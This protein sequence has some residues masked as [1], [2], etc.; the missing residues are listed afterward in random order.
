MS[1]FKDIK[2]G[3]IE[4]PGKFSFLGVIKSTSPQERLKELQKLYNSQEFELYTPEWE[5]KMKAWLDEMNRIIE[6]YPEL[7]PIELKTYI[8]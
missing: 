7:E 2:N 6:L 8:H 1:I 5:L 3:K 4:A